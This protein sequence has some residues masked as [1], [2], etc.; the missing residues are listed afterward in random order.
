ML[1][2]T[3][4]T[5]NTAKGVKVPFCCSSPPAESAYRDHT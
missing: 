5:F 4:K 3:G 2:E 1:T